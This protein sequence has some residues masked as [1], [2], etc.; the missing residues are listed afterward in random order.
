MNDKKPIRLYPFLLPSELRK[1]GF[2]NFGKQVFINR[3]VSIYHP[4]NIAIG[5]NV[6]IDDFC[7]LSAPGDSGKIVPELRLPELE[8]LFIL[9]V[10]HKSKAKPE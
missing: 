3:N 8:F 2:K 7:I 4:H 9:I 10:Q 1:I 6:R 5:N